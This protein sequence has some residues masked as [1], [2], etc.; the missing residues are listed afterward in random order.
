MIHDAIYF[1]MYRKF[2]TRLS[3]VLTMLR[4][5]NETVNIYRSDDVVL[6]FGDDDLQRVF[7]PLASW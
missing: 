4:Y 2:I 7:P 5:N 3:S 6:D 1:A